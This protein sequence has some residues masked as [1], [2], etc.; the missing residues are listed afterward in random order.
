MTGQLDEK[1]KEKRVKKLYAAQ[2]KISRKNNENLV[3][4][5]LKILCDGVDYDKQFFFG[6][7]Y[8]SAPDID[9]KV[10]FTSDKDISQGE[11]YNVLIEKCD[12]YDLY[13]GVIN[14]SAE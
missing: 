2:R 5:T 3:G 13:G 8:F 1:T 10:Y 6:R 9:G 14:E 11:Y 12:D 7:A 4:K